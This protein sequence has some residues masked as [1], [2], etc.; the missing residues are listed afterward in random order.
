MENPK[1]ALTVPVAIVVAGIIIAGAIFF[2]RGTRAKDVFQAPAADT[3]T[4]ET[5][6]IANRPVNANEHIL[7]NPNASIVMVE[8][9]DLE[10][11]F[12]KSF[13]KTM[14]T[15]LDQYGK[16]GQVSWAYRHFPLD[17]HPKSRKESEASECAYEAGGN[18]KFFAFVNKVFEV[19][20]SNN[21]L[22]PS[23]LSEIATQ[24][25]LDGGQIQNCIDS[26]KFA[27]KI[28]A[29]YDDGLKAG[30][31]GTPNTVL[32]LKKNIAP[33]AEKRLREINQTILRQLQPGS[34]SPITIDAGKRKV[35]VSGAFQL[36]MMKEM[37]DILL[38]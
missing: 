10:C 33:S 26:G 31:N 34:P 7:G 8:Y 5:V 23:K 19:T 13:H 15:I 18:D 21:G 12:C 25:G 3:T 37:I 38:K 24:I 16:T 29:D 32:T 27:G 22:D 28:Q 2:S 20:P 1:N 30:V 9:S 6:N 4:Q 14:Q 36:N 11:P 17:I 35:G